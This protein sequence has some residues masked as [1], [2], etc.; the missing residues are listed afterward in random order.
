[1]PFGRLQGAAGPRGV[2]GSP[3][4]GACDQVFAPSAARPGTRALPRHARVLTHQ[5]RKA[6]SHNPHPDRWLRAP[7][8][9]H[10]SR[11]ALSR[12]RHA[13]PVLNQL[14]GI[15]LTTKNGYS[16]NAEL[17]R[18][19]DMDYHQIKLMLD[20]PPVKLLRAQNAPLLLS[21]LHR[22]FKR[23]HHVAIPE[24]QLRAALEAELEERR[25]A[26]PFAYSQT[27]ADYLTLCVGDAQGFLRRYYGPGADEPLYEL[28]SG[29]EKALLWLE[30]L[31]EGRF[32]GTESR[33][34]S[35]F[36][37]LEQIL[38]Y[39]S[40]DP[41][42]RVKRLEDEAAEITRGI[43]RIR[44]TGHVGSF[45]PGRLNERYARVLA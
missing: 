44:A 2:T 45:P 38:K 40:S 21:F 29:S 33:L 24:G 32:V 30:T 6:I 22:I 3:S 12:A 17:R 27:A 11:R 31:R 25:E 20:M 23:E 1:M 35:I 36:T 34:E 19:L 15:F 42:A 16:V 10:R 13:E 43:E 4:H 5:G 7:P 14:D 41:Q 37:E 9:P 8:G 28:T 18:H 39:G 26:E